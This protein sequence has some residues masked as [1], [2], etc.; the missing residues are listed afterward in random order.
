MWNAA[1]RLFGM[2]HREGRE[3]KSEEFGPGRLAEYSLQ[4]NFVW[5]GFRLC[6]SIN[7]D[8]SIP[9]ETKTL[10]FVNTL[11]NKSQERVR[12]KEGDC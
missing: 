2:A 9:G 5:R 8:V 10:S 6:E 11:P 1:I 4:C 12:K 7:P 3:L